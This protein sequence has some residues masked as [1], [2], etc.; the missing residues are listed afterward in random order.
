ML[1]EK[2]VDGYNSIQ[3]RL[4]RLAQYALLGGILL[5]GGGLGCG[6]PQRDSDDTAI[7]E[8]DTT[9]E[10]SFSN[11]IAYF[12]VNGT[13]SE[14]VI[15]DEDGSEV[16]SFS[17]PWEV[18]AYGAPCW[19]PDGRKIIV[20]PLDR[21]NA[22]LFALDISS[23]TLEVLVQ[24]AD[25]TYSFPKAALNGDIAVQASESRDGNT[26]FAEIV[27]VRGTTVERVTHNLMEDYSPAWTP[28]G[29][30]LYVSGSSSMTATR[31]TVFSYDG[32]HSTE[33]RIGVSY[34]Y[35][36]APSPDGPLLAFLGGAFGE[37][38]LYQVP[39]TGGAAELLSSINGRNLQWAPDGRYIVF[40]TGVMSLTHSIYRVDVAEQQLVRLAAEGNSSPSVS[41][42]SEYIVFRS[43]RTGNPNLFKMRRDG[44]EVQPLTS[45]TSPVG[46][47]PAEWQGYCR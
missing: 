38:S 12:L 34:V 35:K 1:L 46:V 19:T 41:R 40:D 47:G 14:L 7:D 22:G 11:R 27:V 26:E 18:N 16:Q 10:N 37:T 6:D 21:A 32:E 29:R 30:L 13:S 43:N 33:V 20:S 23:G 45:Y 15:A 36:L 3:K 39:I 44:T 9:T 8:N 17:F 2:M 28:D 5:A 4:C 31:S 25:V 42:D 24:S